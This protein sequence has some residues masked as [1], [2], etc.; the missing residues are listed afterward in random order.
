MKDPYWTRV[1]GNNLAADVTGQW[2]SSPAPRPKKMAKRLEAVLFYPRKHSPP[3]LQILFRASGQSDF[4]VVIH[5]PSPPSKRSHGATSGGGT[6]SGK[7]LTAIK[8]ESSSAFCPGSSC[9]IEASDSLLQLVLR[10]C[11]ETS[12]LCRKEKCNLQSTFF[13]PFQQPLLKPSGLSL[14]FIHQRHVNFAKEYLLSRIQLIRIFFADET[15]RVFRSFHPKRVQAI[16]ERVLQR[17]HQRPRSWE[18]EHPPFCFPP[19]TMR[20]PW[21]T[22]NP[23]ISLGIISNEAM[24]VSCVRGSVLK[25]S[26][27][28]ITPSLPESYLLSSYRHIA[29][30]HK[31]QGLRKI[32]FSSMAFNESNSGLIRSLWNVSI[33]FTY[34]ER[35]NILFSNFSRFWLPCKK[36]KVLQTRKSQEGRFLSLVSFSLL[37]KK[38]GRERKRKRERKKLRKRET[39]RKTENERERKRKEGR[40]TK[41]KEGKKE[42]K[43]EVKK[44]R[45]RKICSSLE[46][47]P[48]KVGNH[49]A[50]CVENPMGS[51]LG[52]VSAALRYLNIIEFN[53]SF[54]HFQTGWD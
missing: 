15:K 37:K 14:R 43:K 28:Y 17:Q 16:T 34:L 22:V 21:G 4:S 52:R 54:P 31:L 13:P 32:E 6:P 44:E 49:I 33:R 47:R 2:N 25:T 45:R 53:L 9:H 36:V 18:V 48:L 29:R 26:G 20:A 35:R 50:E 1:F 23:H 39:E 12:R 30:T 11:A 8:D 38:E 42:G 7:R 27:L 3:S 46:G 40:K 41:R 19:P 51:G 10:D 5:Q 24:H